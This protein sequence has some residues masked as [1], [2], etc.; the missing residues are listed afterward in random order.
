MTYKA[1]VL[2]SG[3]A[4]S[5]A[6]RL[7]GAAGVKTIVVSSTPIGGRATVGSL[8]PSKGWLNHAHH[9]DG[10]Q[11]M[12]STEV[13]SVAA[14]I[15]SLVEERVGWS[16]E[17]LTAMGVE[18]V[19][20]EGTLMGTRSVEVALGLEPGEGAERRT[21]EAESI[22]IA[23]GSEPIFFPGVKPD[24]KRLIAPRHAKTL[25]ELPGRLVMIGGGVTGVEYASAFAR[26]GTEVT[27]ISYDPLLP[28]S[29]REY[30]G[31][32]K[33]YLES[34]GIAIHTGVA[35]ESAVN[36][37]DDVT[38]T[39]TDGRVFGADYAFI[40][41]GRAGDLTFLGEGSPQLTND[42]R[43]V[44]VDAFGRTNVEGIYACGDVTGAPLSANKAVLQ[45]RKVV[46]AITGREWPA[47]KEHLIEAIY[48]DPQLAQVGPVLD[49]ADRSD[50][51]VVRKS[52]AYSMLG[53]VHDSS[54]GEVKFWVDAD[55]AIL[56][57]AAFGEGAAEILAPVQ[58]A[59]TTGT[60]LDRLSAV[61]FAY[62][63]LSEVVTA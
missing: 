10:S 21:I 50:L 28:R 5:E 7:L 36:N 24:A 39:T 52:Y 41:T 56:G 35:V 33:N 15:R 17:T 14:S 11:V 53:L 27:M 40:A 19:I 34:L 47:G 48:T 20:G 55:G 63:T 49:L 2:G 4:G 6:A 22:V 46:A 1:L 60:T 59:I 58:L 9:L 42:G 51:S 31:R 61:P 13:R 30:V 12:S 37:G 25:T 23:T 26:M 45:A 29:D 57:A 54:G 44:A 32:L 8:L 3:P 16:T 62:P 43:A 18:V 38:V